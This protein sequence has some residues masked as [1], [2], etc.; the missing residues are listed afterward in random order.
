[1]PLIR[2]SLISLAPIRS[3]SLYRQLSVLKL[4]HLLAVTC[5]VILGIACTKPVAEAAPTPP[6]EISIVAGNTDRS[7]GSTPS[8]TAVALATIVPE[9]PTVD[10][11]QRAAGEAGEVGLSTPGLHNLLIE[12]LGPYDESTATFG[13]LQYN[14]DL[15]GLMFESFGRTQLAGQPQEYLN[16]T[17]RFKA[18]L[19]TVL[20]APISGVIT[21]L[22]WQ[23]SNSSLQDDWEMHITETAFSPWVV[24]IDHI[25]S[26]DC[27]R[28]SSPAQ[29]C[30]APL[31]AS[32]E[33]LQVGDSVVVGQPIGYIGNWLRDDTGLI[34]GHTELG[35]FKYADDYSSVTHYCP[36][37]YLDAQLETEYTTRIS[38][39]MNTYEEWRKD[40]FGYA[41]ENMV[42]QGCLFEALTEDDKGRIYPVE[43]Q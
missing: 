8:P 24:G 31:S 23:S 6:Q 4:A 13:D 5:L 18:A 34:F 21:Y 37:R 33:P 11:N 22:E 39:L 43:S 32:G 36:T 40:D 30:D 35:V 17:F 20:I 10:H 41:Q 38:N 12:Q 7:S 16:T 14:T 19:D 9:H 27:E 15:P 2:S 29:P 26:L 28:G 25:V 42:V 3:F 1:M